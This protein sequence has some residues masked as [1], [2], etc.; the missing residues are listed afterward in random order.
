M[1]L[2]DVLYSEKTNAWKIVTIL[3]KIEYQKRDVP[4]ARILCWIGF[5]IYNINAGNAV[6]NVRH[7]KAF[8][9]R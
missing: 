2:F 3:W 7:P 6:T 9:F 8:L 5:D 1:F 4:R